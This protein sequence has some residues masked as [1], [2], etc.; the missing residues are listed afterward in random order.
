MPKDNEKK[1]PAQIIPPTKGATDDKTAS[2]I[3][4]AQV[5]N[6]TNRPDLFLETIEKHDP[7]FIK[8]MN[9]DAEQFNKKARGSMF[10]FGKIQ[11]YTG[12]IISVV[13]AVA[14]LGI[15]VS[16]VFVKNIGFMQILALGIVYAISQAGTSGFANIAGQVAK[17]AGKGEK[18]DDDSTPPGV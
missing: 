8:R 12:L 10:K 15:I 9:A 16:A 13:A 6:Y 18:S 7:G 4:L 11:A 5:S 3:L 14:L 1:P 2:N 17:I